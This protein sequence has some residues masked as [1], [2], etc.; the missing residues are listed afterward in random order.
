[1]GLEVPIVIGIILIILFISI[2]WPGIVGAPWV[3]TSMGMVHKMLKLADVGP[4]DVVYDLGCGDGRTIITAA[5]YYGARAV[6]IE[7]DPL[8]YLWCQ[9]LITVFRL[10]SRIKIIY[11]NFFYKDLSEATLITCYLLQDTNDKLVKKLKKELRPGT[12]VV[13][14][15]FTFSGLQM[16]REDDHVNFYLIPSGND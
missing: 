3:P 10:R 15:F 16:V 4:D 11:G 14:N 12:K 8:R 9:I 1:M 5:R 6:G 7:I 2:F 13:S